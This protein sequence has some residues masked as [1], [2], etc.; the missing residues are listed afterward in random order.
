M[1]FKRKS[2][3]ERVL[4]AIDSLGSGGRRKRQSGASVVMRESLRLIVIGAPVLWSNR[5]KIKQKADTLLNRA[6]Q[7][8]NAS[9]QALK[10]VSTS[11]VE[12]LV[13]QPQKE[14]DSQQVG[15]QPQQQQQ[16]Q[17]QQQQPKSEE[18]DKAA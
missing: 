1:M 18:K 11:G 17:P 3:F 14:E 9:R 2:Q 12:Q 7:R 6:Q 13:Q 16:Q 4:G 8:L 15:Q 5:E 10:A